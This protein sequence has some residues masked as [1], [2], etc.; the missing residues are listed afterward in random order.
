M[1]AKKGCCFTSEA[2]CCDPRR[3]RSFLVRSLRIRFR[4]CD[5]TAGWS[6]KVRRISRMLANVL[7]RLDPLNGVLPYCR[8]QTNDVAG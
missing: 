1:P 3:L 5:E 7:R 8:K 2:P 6:G 4:H